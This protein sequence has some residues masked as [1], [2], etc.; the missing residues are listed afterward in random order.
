M[1]QYLKLVF[2]AAAL[3]ITLTVCSDKGAGPSSGSSSSGGS[4]HGSGAPTESG[5]PGLILAKAV[6]REGGGILPSTLVLLRPTDKTGSS[7]T[8][9]IITAS[10]ANIRLG[11]GTLAD[12]TPVVCEVK[13]TANSTPDEL[14]YAAS[15]GPMAFVPDDTNWSLTPVEG[16]VSWTMSGEG[17]SETIATKEYEMRGGNVFHKA[18]WWDPVFGEPGILTISAN[19]PFMQIWRRVDNKWTPETIWSQIVGGREQ[20]LRDVEIG[21]VD[22]DGQ[23]ELVVATHDNGAIYVLEQTEGGL[24]A[25]E[26]HRWEERTFAHEVEMGDV[27]GDGKP[28][29]FTTPSEPNRSDGKRQAGWIDMYRHT[30]A[31]GYERINVAELTDRHAKEIMVADY[32]GDGIVELYAALEAKGTVDKV[33]AVRRWV[34]DGSK[35]AED[36]TVEIDGK[37]CRFLVLADTTGDGV[38][39]IIASTET[40][41]IFRIQ[42]EEGEWVTKKIVMSYMSGGFEHA[43]YALDWD[44]DGADELFVASDAQ[45][46]MNMFRFNRETGSYKPS[47]IASWKDIGYMVWNV[48]PLPVGK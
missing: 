18:M 41:G 29:F 25:T 38:N 16:E 39:E 21:D 46:K 15:S 35:M 31:G 26:L 19:M 48:M 9:E 20:R 33:N 36:A 47:G 12:G 7:W 32:D 17:D 14:L 8:E 4:T 44:G 13:E 28:E 1:N 43:T 45:K 10:A 40:A 42:Q 24:V 2:A 6:F 11:L 30:D 22:G 23:D 5:M 27:D 37:A 34:W 3:A